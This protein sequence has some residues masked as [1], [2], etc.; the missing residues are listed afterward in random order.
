[1]KEHLWPGP[2][3]RPD[4]PHASQIFWVLYWIMTGVHA[5][6]VTVGI[7]VISFMAWLSAKRR[8]SPEYHTPVEMTGLYWHFVDVIWIFLY[9]LLYL[10]NRYSA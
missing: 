6:H 1:L 10:I 4:L 3:F 8:F 7:C 5:V 9:P 2:H